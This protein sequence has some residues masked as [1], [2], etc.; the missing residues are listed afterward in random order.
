MI[1]IKMY[2]IM[3]NDRLQWDDDI[4]YFKMKNSESKAGASYSGS[5]ADGLKSFSM[6]EIY[7]HMWL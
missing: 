7:L 4:S 3:S 6:E 2:I 5:A 1:N